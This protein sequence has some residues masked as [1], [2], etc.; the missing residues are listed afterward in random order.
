MEQKILNALK[1]KY[2]NLGLGDKILGGFAK[3][4][5]K[6]VKEETEIETAVIGVED[7]LKMWQSINDTH[8][9][10]VA[11]L[12]KLIE[13]AKGKTTTDEG[14]AGD[15][16]KTGKSNDEGKT[17]MPQ[18]AKEI[19]SEVKTLRGEKVA[20][21]RKGIL[22]EKIKTAPEAIKSKILKDFT[23][24]NFENDDDFNAFITETETDVAAITQA[25]PPATN[26]KPLISIGGGEVSQSRVTEAI[27]Q[28]AA[29]FSNQ[30]N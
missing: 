5:A 14:G 8:R 26:P 21:T 18:W 7:E 2:A 29:K 11:D 30:K 15:E 20:Q 23:K 25:L 4:L 3:K 9:T 12:K 28:H 13:A 6:T 19:L 1:N 27:K 17:S 16:G 10:E 22:A 24:M